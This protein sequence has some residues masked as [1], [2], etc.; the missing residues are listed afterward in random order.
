MPGKT[1]R[2]AATGARVQLDL[3]KTCCSVTGVAGRDAQ[4]DTANASFSASRI[5]KLML[6]GLMRAVV[7]VD[8]V[9]ASNNWR[10]RPRW[11]RSALKKTSDGV[12]KTG[13]SSCESARDRVYRGVA[14][15]SARGE[16]VRRSLPAL[17][18]G[19]AYE[20]A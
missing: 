18:C 13:V 7:R 12:S 2:L 16:L 5:E 3:E 19:H 11:I 4:W 20:R 9:K 15:V 6:W 17:E 8:T 10:P 1:T 14:Q